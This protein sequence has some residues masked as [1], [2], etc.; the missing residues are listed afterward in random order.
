[1]STPRNSPDQSGNMSQ[2]FHLSDDAP[3]TIGE[4]IRAKAERN[5]S[6]IALEIVD[7]TK[8]YRQI[9]VDSDRVAVGLMSLGLQPGDRAAIMM[10]NSLENVDTWF[11][12][13]K[14][15]ILEVPINTSNRSVSVACCC[16]GQRISCPHRRDCCRPAKS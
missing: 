1:M 16:R 5:D 8:T 3:R 14:L 6:K 2:T 7:R 9:D 11:A 10:K 13:C 4:W 15:N 12:M